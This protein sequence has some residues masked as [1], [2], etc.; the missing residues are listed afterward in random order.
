M[1]YAH[2][3]TKQII[4]TNRLAFLVGWSQTIIYI[5]DQYDTH[6]SQYTYTNLVKCSQQEKVSPLL[7]G[8]GL[9]EPVPTPLVEP[10]IAAGD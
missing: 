6:Y 3:S 1:W 9:S 10:E 4:I 2:H 7:G 8:N 5:I